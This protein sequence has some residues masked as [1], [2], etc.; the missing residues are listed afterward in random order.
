MWVAV[1]FVRRA[2]HPCS[3]RDGPRQIPRDRKV[4][5]ADSRPLAEIHR[6]QMQ[7]L[8]LKCKIRVQ[9]A[10]TAQPSLDA[11]LIL[12]EVPDS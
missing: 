10:A 3:A 1:L 12:A 8:R 4:E 9:E 7:T 2:G 5:A 6:A 11:G